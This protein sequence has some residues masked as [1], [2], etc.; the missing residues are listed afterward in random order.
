MFKESGYSYVRFRVYSKIIVVSHVA[1]KVMKPVGIIIILFLAAGF[2]NPSNG[3][4]TADRKIITGYVTNINHSPV[5]GAF[6]MINKKNS[7]VITD[8]RGFYKVRA[9]PGAISIGVYSFTY[10][11]IEENIDQRTRINFTFS[12]SVPVRDISQNYDKD[13]DLD[14]EINVGYGTRTR[15]NLTTSV[16]KIDGR[17]PR[18]DTY[19]SVYDMLQGSVPGVMVRRDQVLIRGFSSYVGSNEPLYVVDGTPVSS[20]K[21]I[22]PQM[23]KSISVLKGPA[24]AIYGSRGANGV[25]LIDLLDASGVKKDTSA[26][27]I[28]VPFATTQPATNIQGKTATL[29][30]FVNPNDVS[31]FVTFEYGSNSGY[32]SKI[33]AQQSPV[34]GNSSYSISAVVTNLQA[35]TTYH[36]RVVATNPFGSTVGVDIPFTTLG[37]NPVVKSD[38]AT[39]VTPGTAQLNGI[40]DARHLSTT[41]TFEYG[42][43]TDYGMRVPAAQSPL[44]GN[45]P[46][47]VNANVTGLNA[48]TTYHYRVVAANEKGTAYGA[49]ALFKAEYNLGEYIHGGYIFY[50][51]ETGEHGLVCAPADQSQ[52]ALWGNCTPPGAAGKAIGT[53]SKNTSDIVNGCSERISA[54]RLCY[55]LEMN[56]FDD[57][58]LPSINE[59][60]MMYTN[61]HEKGL[62]GFKESHYWSSTQ[63]KYGAWVVSF[64]YGR[65]SNHSRD[66][67][68]ILTRAV[69]AF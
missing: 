18:F 42:T 51:D 3:Q 65:K 60:M 16:S 22:S 63:D 47:R 67:N 26:V 7:G 36:Y 56:G 25:I 1:E 46:G 19:N 34:S 6:I 23:V 37:G 17:D 31:T 9:K 20:I 13:P 11:I 29:N 62:G 32:G 55:E 41:V 40:V 28:K 24:A 33:A 44:T 4:K 54:A 43:D 8:E 21:D 68:E 69:R 58:F 10:G 5:V 49:D 66:E 38:A 14:E 59:L 50:I 35:G 57:W 45:A 15:R 64:Y 39:E 27:V 12:S 30:G 48:G 2:V 52:V 61:L 53:G